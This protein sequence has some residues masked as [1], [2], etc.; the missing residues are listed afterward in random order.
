MLRVGFPFFSYSKRK[1]SWAIILTQP[2]E[3]DHILEAMVFHDPSND[4]VK[5]L[6]PRHGHHSGTTIQNLKSDRI[7]EGAEFSSD[8]GHA[9]TVHGYYGPNPYVWS[10]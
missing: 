9:N 2:E 1:Y 6:S 7:A 4:S 10:M 8:T 5:D 3:I